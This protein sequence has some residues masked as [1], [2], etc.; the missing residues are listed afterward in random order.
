MRGLGGG[1]APA[2]PG[3][4]SESLFWGQNGLL[5]YLSNP[6]SEQPSV[7][8]DTLPGMEELQEEQCLVRIASFWKD[9][10][11]SHWPPAGA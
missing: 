5:S 9:P 8:R 11:S 7:P 10:C 6:V 2:S 4:S 3:P 1:A